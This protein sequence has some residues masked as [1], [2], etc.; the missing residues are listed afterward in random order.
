[1]LGE[2][3]SAERKRPEL[4]MMMKTLM[5][6]DEW[7]QEFLVKSEKFENVIQR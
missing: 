4:T 7:K 5:E 1:M 6:D 2:T 3:E